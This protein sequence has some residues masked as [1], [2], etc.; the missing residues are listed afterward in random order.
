MRRL[1]FWG[2]CAA[3]YLGMAG[4]AAAAEVVPLPAAHAH[5]DYEHARPLLDA[6]ERGFGQVEAD[7]HLVGGELLVA[8]DAKDVRPGRTLTALYLDPLRARAKA[9]G[10]RV[11]RG[12]PT[13]T[14]L[15]DVKTEAKTTY[16]ALDAVLRTYA[17]LLTEFRGGAMTER[18]VTVVV[19]GNRA[20][21]DIAAQ[22]V[23]FAAVD[24]RSVDL[25]SAA[26]PTLVPWISENWKKI[27]AW[28]WEGPMPE[29]ERLALGHWVAR[30]HAQ[31]RKVRFWN[32][33]DRPEAWRVLRA[34]GVDVIG[35]D[36]LAGLAAFLRAETAR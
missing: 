18:A 11:Y 1:V 35:T 21:A 16:A 19:S 32:T 12:G 14:L 13:L 25:E 5:N 17:E 26:P 23:R 6:L 30:A 29:A 24:G 22:S 27:F 20:T 8:H 7:V 10:G 36:D 33:P 9:N 28:H 4:G 3:G 34:A 15:V 31:G 2:L